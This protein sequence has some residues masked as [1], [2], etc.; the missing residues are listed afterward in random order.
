MIAA[1]FCCSN[2]C[3]AAIDLVADGIVDLDAIL[4]DDY[5]PVSADEALT[6]ACRDPVAV[7]SV[8][9]PAT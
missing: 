3:P 4:T 9:T 5:R 8:V 2:A 6:A 1:T 7:D